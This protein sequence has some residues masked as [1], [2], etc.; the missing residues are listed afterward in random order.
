[1]IR[2]GAEAVMLVLGI[3]CK[4]RLSLV[5]GFDGTE[6]IINQL[7]ADSYEN[8]LCECQVT[9]RLHLVAGY[10]AIPLP[11]SVEKLSSTKPVPGAKKAGDC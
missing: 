11:Q 1:M 2:G 6:S 7:L 9:I 5:E 3:G 8:P 10:K 4:Y